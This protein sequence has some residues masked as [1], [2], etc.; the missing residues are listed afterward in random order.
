MNPLSWPSRVAEELYFGGL[1]SHPLVAGLLGPAVGAAVATC[2]SSV[3]RHL[4]E[5]ARMVLGSTASAASVRRLARAMSASMQLAIAEV[6][7][8]SG[9]TSDELAN[10]VTSFSGH[11]AYARLRRERP[12]MVLAGIHMGSFEPCLALLKRHE[13]KLHVLFHPDPV[14]SFERA[15]SAMRREIGVTEHRVSDGM[16]AWHAVQ[17]ALEEGDVVVVHADRTMLGQSGTPMRFLDTDDVMLPTG[18]LRLAA[19]VGAPLVPVFCRRTPGGLH[20]EI[21]E[22]I[23]HD[24]ALLRGEQAARHPSQA[25]LIRAMESA[26]RNDP[27]QWM[28]FGAMRQRSQR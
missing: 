14:P 22:P 9:C 17:H 18:P 21:H 12:G 15:R 24:R 5:N 7:Q 23:L 27:E 19:S 3:A 25:R 2:P 13:P 4:H 20:V 1:R 16:A 26:I 10:R 8:S 28:P 11:E 6:L